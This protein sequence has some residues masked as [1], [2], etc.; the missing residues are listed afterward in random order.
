[1]GKAA[2]KLV[3][4][5]ARESA[6][7]STDEPAST[8]TN[9]SDSESAHDSKN[10]STTDSTNKPTTDSTNKTANKSTNRSA[11]RS[12]NRNAR[13]K[14][15]DRDDD[16]PAPSASER[17]LFGGPL[18]YDMGWSQH[19]DAFME[20]NFR[21]MVTRLPSLLASSFRLAWTADRRA[22]RIVLSAE[23]ARGAAQ[24]VSLLAVN[25]VLGG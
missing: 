23:L 15:R 21:A 25:S 17:L 6:N 11:N 1:M 19:S 16:K 12:A 2:G 10:K 7:E 22:A 20:L 13:K 5:S 4:E 8:S 9:D 18:R 14:K 24:A 3:D